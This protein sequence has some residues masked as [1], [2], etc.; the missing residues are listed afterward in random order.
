MSK[1]KQ[2][3]KLKFYAYELNK[4][5]QIPR[6]LFVLICKFD[7]NTSETEIR[8]L[9]ELTEHLLRVKGYYKRNGK[10]RDEAN[11]LVLSAYKKF[12]EMNK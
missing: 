11:N 5:Y 3:K 6:D 2:L 10:E 12:C 8:F 7:E 4:N 9:K 1:N